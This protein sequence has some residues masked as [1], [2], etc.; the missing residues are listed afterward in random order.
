MDWIKQK[1][2]WAGI[3]GLVASAGGF[4]TGGIPAPEAIQLAVGS[5]IAIFMRQGIA[6]VGK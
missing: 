1:T 3:A 4:F 6:K 2:T 5:M